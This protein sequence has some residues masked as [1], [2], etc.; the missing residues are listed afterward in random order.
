M[1]GATP[2]VAVAIN[3][4]NTIV[5]GAPGRASSSSSLLAVQPIRL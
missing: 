3:V 4:V 5:L 2:P 1:H